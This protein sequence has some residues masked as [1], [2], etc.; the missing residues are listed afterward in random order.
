MPRNAGN[1]SDAARCYQRATGMRPVVDDSTF[2][3][4]Q[5]HTEPHT[6]QNPPTLVCACRGGVLAARGAR[7]GTD[8]MAKEADVM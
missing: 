8:W 7:P 4:L 6:P 3:C 5:G 2:A 1:G